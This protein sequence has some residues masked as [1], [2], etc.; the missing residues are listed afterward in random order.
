MDIFQFIAGLETD[1]GLPKLPGASF[2]DYYSHLFRASLESSHGDY[3][4]HCILNFAVQ[5]LAVVCRIAPRHHRYYFAGGVSAHD[6]SASVLGMVPF[7]EAFLY[8]SSEDSR[9]V[10]LSREL[11]AGRPD[12]DL[13]EF[14]TVISPPLEFLQSQEPETFGLV[15]LLS[16]S[17]LVFSDDAVPA[18]IN[19]LCVGGT[20]LI[21]LPSVGEAPGVC[22]KAKEAGI[23]PSVFSVFPGLE[24]VPFGEDSLCILRRPWPV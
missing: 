1:E 5:Q 14:K 12:D 21:S 19:T 22:R 16:N 18:V 23:E 7:L 9:T 24:C 11:L 13:K 8:A 20:A 4:R 17:E 6:F 3:V 10:K 15:A 2:N